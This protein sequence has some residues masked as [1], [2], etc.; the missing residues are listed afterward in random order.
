MRLANFL[1][2]NPVEKLRCGYW[3]EL[4]RKAAKNIYNCALWRLHYMYDEFVTEL[5]PSIRRE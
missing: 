5:R 4:A 1:L 3:N 2:V